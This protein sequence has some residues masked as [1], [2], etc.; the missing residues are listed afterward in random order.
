MPLRP[1]QGLA[2]YAVARLALAAAFLCA[3]CTTL[4]ISTPEA[5]R[6][7]AAPIRVSISG[8]GNFEPGSFRATIDGADVTSAFTMS[9]DSGVASLALADGDHTLQA[10]ANVW[11]KHSAAYLARSATVAKFTTGPPGAIDLQIPSPVIAIAPST[12]QQLP[13][14][15][16]RSGAF[17]GEVNVATAL[18]GSTI[19]YG[20]AYTGSLTPTAPSPA[21]VEVRNTDVVA[22]G[23]L[24]SGIVSDREPL[25]IRLTHRP[26]LLSPATVAVRQALG[27]AVGPDGVT[28]LTVQ[29]G[30]P[31][32]RRFEAVFRRNSLAVGSPIGFDPG[33]P[34]F[35][36]AGFCPAGEGV[37]VISGG[38]ASAA[39]EVSIFLFH[40]PSDVQTFS[41][42][43][44]ASG[45]VNVIEPKLFFGPACGVIVMTGVDPATPGGFRATAFDLIR[46]QPLCNATSSQPQL[47]AQ[48]LPPVAGNQILSIALGGQQTD[49]PIF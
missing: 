41:L 6:T 39:H 5:N 16:G 44:T 29:N 8:S 43:A 46:K 26:A 19:I 18:G 36:G 49:C 20:N 33:S 27:T 10:F 28:Q 23:S 40:D 37:F 30:P 9:S 47:Q 13:V 48:L 12:T 1:G 24:Y 25:T 32:A 45:S 15:I 22:S 31:G 21:R 11:D 3:A 17:T 38:S 7:Y 2:P 34:A 4:T 14:W 42:P 35:G